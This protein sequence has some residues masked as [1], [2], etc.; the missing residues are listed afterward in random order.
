MLKAVKAS[1]KALVYFVKSKAKPNRAAAW[2][3]VKLTHKLKAPIFLNKLKTGA[4][5]LDFG[6][7][8]YSGWGVEPPEDIK[9]K[10]K[11]EFS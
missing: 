2:Y 7:V 11:E 6:T 1:E 5:L 4:N 8:L 10:I 3:Y 9:K